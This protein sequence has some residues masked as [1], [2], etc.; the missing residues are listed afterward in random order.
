[1]KQ[2][3]YHGYRSFQY[4]EPGADYRPFHLAQEIDRVEPFAYPV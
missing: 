3:E 2:K 4:L 1:M